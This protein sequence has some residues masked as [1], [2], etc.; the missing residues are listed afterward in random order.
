MGSPGS[1][2]KKNVVRKSPTLV[3]KPKLK[4]SAKKTITSKKVFNH[5]K[6]IH[7]VHYLMDQIKHEQKKKTKCR[8]LCE[9]LLFLLSLIAFVMIPGVAY[10]MLTWHYSGKDYR[11]DMDLDYWKPDIDVPALPEL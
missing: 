2:E 10:T 5:A 11:T 8:M 9:N 4:A 6:N 1:G 7:E 3:T